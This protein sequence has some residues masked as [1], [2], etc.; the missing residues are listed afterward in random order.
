MVAVAADDAVD[1][2]TPRER[3]LIARLPAP[4][5][6][7]S[8]RDVARVAVEAF[9]IVGRARASS[10]RTWRAYAR[11]LARET[12]PTDAADV[13]ASRAGRR[14]D[15]DADE[16]SV[17]ESLVDG[18]ATCARCGRAV[19]AESLD[20]HAARRC[21][22]GA[23]KRA[24]DVGVR[25]VEMVREETGMDG[26]GRGRM[27]SR[28][29]GGGRAGGGRAGG[30]RGGGGRGGGG[31]ASETCA[32]V[33]KPLAVRVDVREARRAHDATVFRIMFDARASAEEADASPETSARAKKVA[34]VEAV[35]V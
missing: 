19:P 13:S 23:A 24:R 32:W 5:R 16:R 22:G 17:L 18:L 12:P 35:G 2:A 15:A 8:A 26:R 10:S 28:G 4:L 33:A 29:R 31:R 11:A 14:A 30:G 20:A 7:M 9:G 6:S 27:E 3:E 34:K 21:D 1:D 25:A